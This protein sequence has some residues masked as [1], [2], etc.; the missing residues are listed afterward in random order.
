MGGS[1]DHVVMLVLLRVMLL[2]TSPIWILYVVKVNDSNS[3][4]ESIATGCEKCE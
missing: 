1:W 3:S 4:L 2:V